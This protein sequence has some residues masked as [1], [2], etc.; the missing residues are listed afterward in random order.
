MENLKNKIQ[1]A[2]NAAEILLETKL[3]RQA[4]TRYWEA[5]RSAIFYHLNEQN[6]NYSSTKQALRKIIKE[7]QGDNLSEKI[8]FV[9]L[10]GVLCEWD[11]YFEIDMNQMNDYANICSEIISRFVEVSF[12]NKEVYYF[13]LKKE[14]NRREVDILWTK[15]I[16]YK[17]AERMELCYN[18]WLGWGFCITL[19]GLSCF[20]CSVT[21]LCDCKK[22][23]GSLITLVGAGVTLWPLIKDF[24]GKAV[25]HKRAADELHNLHMQCK[26]WETEYY[27]SSIEI[28]RFFVLSIRSSYKLICS[29][30]PHTTKGDFRN[31]EKDINKKDYE[32]NNKLL[33]N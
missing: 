24:T 7:Y 12:S 16:H 32:Y 15:T 1:E 22:W 8:I 26:N 6:I 17:A 31:A 28:M 3:Y 5:T 19:L 14:I 18:R 25:R 21:N 29:L 4:V 13:Y 23:I 20:F 30:A 2:V 9:E 27:R 33:N 10:I 11:E